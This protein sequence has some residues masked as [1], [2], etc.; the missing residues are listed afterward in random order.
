MNYH[1][2]LEFIHSLGNFSHKAGLERITEVLRKL[3]NPQ[4][5]LKAIHVAGTNGKGSVSAML[6]RVLSLAGYKTGLFISPFIIDFRERIQ[7][8]GEYI[9]EEELCAYAKRV[10][11]AGVALTEFEFITAIA[12]LYFEEKSVD[13]LVC[14]TGLGGRLDATNTLCQKIACV[15]TKIGMDHTL[16]LGDTLST[17][18]RE[19]C[20]IIKNCVTVTDPCQEAEAMKVIKSAAKELI[21]P[22]TDA[23]EIVKSDD[24]SNTFIYKGEKYDLSLCG[25]FQVQNA[26]VVLETLDATGLDIPYNIIYEGLKTT[27]FPARM[28]MLSREPVIIL[29]G[30]HNPDGAAVLAK[31]LQ[32]YSGKVTAV[33]GMMRDKDCREVL[34]KTLIHCKKAFSVEV[35]NM[36]RSLSA[37]ELCL[38]ASEFT[39]CTPMESYEAA[40]AAAKAVADG[41]I[42]IFG[43][44]YLA[45]GIRKK[46][47]N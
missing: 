29:D 14:E 35:E 7:I 38:V 6:S 30:A 24:F 16:I 42:F 36:P 32:K 1:E 17:I 5:N 18:A 4:K 40:L 41:P 2:T 23:L 10:L 31:E 27:S 12:F 47:K 33:I 13:F 44:L 43:S 22:N 9:S 45:A 20:G 11:E 15:I 37:S 28:E 39:E 46:L 21:I 3:G 25:N 26:L 19:K 8:N 34:Q